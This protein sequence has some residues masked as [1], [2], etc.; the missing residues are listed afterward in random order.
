MTARR[1]HVTVFC[2]RKKRLLAGASMHVSRHGVCT[3]GLRWTGWV[4]DGI[5]PSVMTDEMRARLYPFWD[6]NLTPA[7]RGPVNISRRRNVKQ[8]CS[9]LQ[10]IL[11]CRN[12]ISI[13]TTQHEQSTRKSKACFPDM[14]H[15]LDNYVISD[16]RLTTG[17]IRLE[18]VMGST[19]ARHN[20]WPV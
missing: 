2:V 3:P 19:V 10:P 8:D 16:V 6:I 7:A 11:Q 1:R 18:T 15:I 17:K 4:M 20:A 12:I 13:Q 9:G 5:L 14:K